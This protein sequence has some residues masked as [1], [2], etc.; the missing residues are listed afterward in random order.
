MKLK[1]N[2]NI[3]HMDINMD[4][5]MDMDMKNNKFKDYKSIDSLCS[6]DSRS[7]SVDSRCRSI[8]GG[9]IGS[10]G[11]IETVDLSKEPSKNNTYTN[12]IIIV[13]VEKKK[14]VRD[15]YIEEYISPSPNPQYYLQS[16]NISEL[17]LLPENT[18]DTKKNTKK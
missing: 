15:I 17:C 13:D 16:L 12:E 6:I 8:S 10:L 4:M 11:S 14:R 1:N 3:I 2:I 5:D 18:N 7:R 9:S